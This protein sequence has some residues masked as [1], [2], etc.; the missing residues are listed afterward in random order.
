MSRYKIPFPRWI[1]E[2]MCPTILA[3]QKELLKV[4]K[5]RTTCSGQATCRLHAEFEDTQDSRRDASAR[6][7]KSVFVPKE[8]R[9]GQTT[10]G[11]STQDIEFVISHDGIENI[12]AIM[13][14]ARD[15]DN[16]LVIGLEPQ[17]LP[18]P[19][20][21]GGDGA[22]LNVPSFVLP[23]DVRNIG[24]AKVWIAGKFHVK[25][26]HVS[27]LGESYFTHTGVTPQ[28]IYP[29]VVANPGKASIYQWHYSPLANFLGTMRAYSWFYSMSSVTVKMI[30]R[31]HIY[32][33]DHNLDMTLYRDGANL[34]NQ[35]FSLSTEKVAL[36]TK[37]SGYAAPSRVMGQRGGDAGGGGWQQRHGR[38]QGRRISGVERD[39]GSS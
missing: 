11:L 3:G 22:M 33:N 31:T 10:R 21:L 17:I 6:R 26:E 28:R 39:S 32:M 4:R 18:V 16:A 13:P 8:G 23:P 12:A 37:S 25:P 24:E 36:D 9:V 34:R 38:G 30:A 27:Q 14:L 29:F 20:R 35:G 1:G 19:N 2:T 5:S 7:F 15:G